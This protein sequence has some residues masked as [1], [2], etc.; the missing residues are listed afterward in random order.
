MLSLI[1]SKANRKPFGWCSSVRRIVL[2]VIRSKCQAF[3]AMVSCSFQKR[4]SLCE[5]KRKASEHGAMEQ[6]DGVWSVADVVNVAV[7][8]Q[9]A[10]HGGRVQ[11]DALCALSVIDVHHSDFILSR[12]HCRAANRD[13][14]PSVFWWTKSPRESTGSNVTRNW[15]AS[16]QGFFTVLRNCPSNSGPVR[17][18]TWSMRR[19]FSA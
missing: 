18:S 6:D 9:A 5:Q 8:A 4:N 16:A 10:D 13:S 14:E 19:P 15:V 1:Y 7:G 3:A 2:S 12:P 17:E 11:G